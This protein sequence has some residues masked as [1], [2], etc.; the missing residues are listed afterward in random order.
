MNATVTS[1]AIVGVEPCP[2]E[3]EAHVGGGRPSFVIVG[4]PDA[5]VREA[6]ERVRAAMA[7]ASHDFPARR[8]VVNLA[9]ADL[10]KV[11]SAYDLPIALGVLAADGKVPHTAT[12]V[13]AL[14]ASAEG[15]PA[16]S[17]G[18][19]AAAGS[20]TTTVPLIDGWM[21]QK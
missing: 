3:V 20:R 17:P 11:G 4:L 9:P 10:P 6:K 5:A 12:D 16:G 15:S 2:V 19:S 21:A 13:V 8:V 7:S 18:S 14:T 1:S